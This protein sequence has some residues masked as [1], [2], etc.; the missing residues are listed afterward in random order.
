MEH[1]NHTLKKKRFKSLRTRQ[2]FQD[3]KSKLKQKLGDKLQ[4][5]SLTGTTKLNP[6][7]T[8]LL[9]INHKNN[10]CTNIENARQGSKRKDNV[11]LSTQEPGD[12][13]LDSIVLNSTPITKVRILPVDFS[14]NVSL[15]KIVFLPEPL[16]TPSPKTSP[17]HEED[18]M[19]D[20]LSFDSNYRG[21]PNLSLYDSL[22]SD[23]GKLSC[24]NGD[25]D[26][27]LSEVR[28]VANVPLE[29][30]SANRLLSFDDVTD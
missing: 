22:R 23:D 16:F 11:L 3:K 14:S 26:S 28:S 9:P 19:S 10:S 7:P 29:S 5:L 15:D 27:L 2:Y 4:H 13:T 1:N 24:D 8:K 18:S 25:D 17:F 21:E 30:V 20:C 12:V 6:H